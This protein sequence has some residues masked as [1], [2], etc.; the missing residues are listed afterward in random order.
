MLSCEGNTP[1]VL[2]D[3]VVVP[4][5]YDRLIWRCCRSREIRYIFSRVRCIIVHQH[6]ATP[7]LQGNMVQ[8]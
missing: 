6:M 7:M 1:I 2:Y 5:K 8:H 3:D 4:G